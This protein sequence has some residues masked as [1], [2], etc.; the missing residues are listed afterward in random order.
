MYKRQ[1]LKAWHL[2][3]GEKDPTLRSKRIWKFVQGLKRAT[4]GKPRKMGVTPAMLQ[5][6]FVHLFGAADA[7]PL[8]NPDGVALF[9]TI[10]V[11]FFFMLRA[12]EYLRTGTPDDGRVLK[13]SSLSLKV[14]GVPT[15][16]RP[17]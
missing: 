15:R 2:Q 16:G 17:D 12:G 4:V 10:L 6:I 5:W 3:A 9:A 7:D 1:A 8:Q 14:E 11:G 13:G